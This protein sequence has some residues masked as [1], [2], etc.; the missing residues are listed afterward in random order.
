[1]VG[2]QE[3]TRLQLFYCLIIHI[4][5]VTGSILD[6]LSVEEETGLDHSERRKKEMMEEEPEEAQG[7]PV[8]PF[9]LQGHT[10][11]SSFSPSSSFTSSYPRTRRSV[12]I[13]EICCE[14]GCNLN[15]LSWR[16]C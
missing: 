3:A 2:P 12:R 16:Y 9:D 8:L 1:M 10:S 4:V 7:A 14:F 5:A 15:E 11:S 13:E 6:W